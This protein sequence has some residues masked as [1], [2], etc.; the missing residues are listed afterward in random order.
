[1]KKI[2]AIVLAAVLCAVCLLAVSC[3]SKTNDS[4]KTD[5]ITS[6]TK[7]G[8]LEMLTDFLDKAYE[9]PDMTINAKYGD[10]A[11][12][13]QQLKGTDTSI[14]Y[15]DGTKCYAYKLDDFY[16]YVFDGVNERYYYTSDETKSSY[17]EETK[18]FYD[19]DYY[20]LVDDFKSYAEICDTFNAELEKTKDEKGT[21]SSLKINL[22]GDKVVMSIEATAENDLVK[23]V[24]LKS[25]TGE[26]QV[27][28]TYTFTY[29]NAKTVYPDLDSW[30]QDEGDAAT[31]AQANKDALSLRDAF[32]YEAFN[33]DNIKVTY[34]SSKN[35]FVEIIANEIDKVDHTAGDTSYT[36]YTFTDEI[37]G[38]EKKVF[39]LE[40]TDY[41]GSPANDV[42]IDPSGD[43]YETNS[44]IYVS[45]MY[46]LQ[47]GEDDILTSNITCSIVDEELTLTIDRG[48]DGKTVLTAVMEDDK[49]TEASITTLDKEGNETSC[50]YT[51]EYDNQYLNKPDISKY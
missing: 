29:G 38:E 35:S 18:E 33:S 12:F 51:F 19:K 50:T 31:K 21:Y 3:G 24:V 17:N 34:T 40:K 28:V 22:T 20:G 39:I 27:I 1:M 42:L 47:V 6:D 36:I 30:I 8:S 5:K 13:T 26:D 49:V 14:E 43:I 32:F 37:E 10:E 23:Q 2:S 16:Y 45:G 25:T 46:G 44:R 15:A 9:N 48:N 41:D 4:P 11:V 7:E